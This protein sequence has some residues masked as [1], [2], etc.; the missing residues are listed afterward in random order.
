MT[1]QEF[2]NEY[3]TKNNSKKVIQ[4]HII[5]KYVPITMKQEVCK[6]IVELSSYEIVD[7][8][9]TYQRN[10]TLLYMLFMMAIVRLYTDIEIQEEKQIADFLCLEECGAIEEICGSISEIEM[11][12]FNTIMKMCQ[13]D[14]MDNDRSL[15]SY[16]D[17]FASSFEYLLN[18]FEKILDINQ[19][20]IEE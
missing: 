5:T 19:L 12:R 10:S 15:L 14:F 9:K 13:D 11:D 16:I 7:Q 3:T 18:E 8:R 2:V 17:H 4:E 1:V 6:K 20:N